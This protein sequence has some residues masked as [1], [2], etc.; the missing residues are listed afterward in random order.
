MVSD[1]TE[2]VCLTIQALLAAKGERA[3][4]ERQL[5]RRLRM[6]FA[7]LP[8]GVGLA[9]LRA[10]IRLWLG[11]CPER[12]GVFSAG[13]GPAARSVVL[14][15]IVDDVQRVI[16]LT[17]RSTRITHSDPKATHGAVTLALAAH[18][19]AKEPAPDPTRFVRYVIEHYTPL[20]SELKELI[21]RAAGSAAEG[22]S[23]SAF[24]RSLGLERG[25]SGYMYHTVPVCVQAW[26]RH[27]NDFEA[28]VNA[29]I[30]CGGDTDSVAAIVGG[31]IGTGIGAESLPPHWL[32]GIVEWPRSVEWMN[33]L[34]RRAAV[35][36]EGTVPELPLPATMVRNVGF[37]VVVL[38]HGFR[39]LLPPY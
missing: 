20:E 1:D 29:V 3:E 28:G 12:S 21:I 31:L 14:G 23:T 7:C 16:D 27:A 38:G 17:S 6:W 5:A 11:V 13:N 30:A 26:L 15:A 24:A 19:A 34:A 33:L 25:V 35:P 18:L 10:C 37:L 2:H 32:Y 22:Q 4:F 39:R 9:T 36:L 8:A